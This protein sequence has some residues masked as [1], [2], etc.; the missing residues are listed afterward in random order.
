MMALDVQSL[1][2]EATQATQLVYKTSLP[3][4]SLGLHPKFWTAIPAVGFAQT[5][6]AMVS[7]LEAYSSNES[8]PRVPDAISNIP[9]V[10][11]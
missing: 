7:I 3:A 10:A 1:F 9:I 4:G 2:A 11:A 8:L 5:D 6:P